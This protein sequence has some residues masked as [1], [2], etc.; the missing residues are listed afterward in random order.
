MRTN[1]ISMRFGFRFGR[2]TSATHNPNYHHKATARVRFGSN[3]QRG[4]ALEAIPIWLDFK[5][6]AFREVVLCVCENNAIFLL[7]DNH[8]DWFQ[9]DKI[10]NLFED[11]KTKRT[12]KLSSG[13]WN[14]K[15]YI[16]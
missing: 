5:Y 4:V 15:K 16:V 10:L 11:Y 7:L 9:F 13:V 12:S 8:T 1:L 2:T 3:H 6:G 14:Y